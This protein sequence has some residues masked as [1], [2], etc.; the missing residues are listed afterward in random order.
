MKA[1]R[2]AVDVAPI[3]PANT[4]D[5]KTLM[6]TFLLEK[7]I[8]ELNYEMNNRPD[9]LIIPLQGIQEILHDADENRVPAEEPVEADY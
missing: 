2:E 8:Y 4:E 6:T 3:V 7:A 1:Y 9:W 5:L